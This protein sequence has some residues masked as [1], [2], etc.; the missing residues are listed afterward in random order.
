MLELGIYASHIIWRIR[1]RK[2]R[3]EAKARGKSIDE[4][5]DAQKNGTEGPRD[6]ESGVV[7]AEGPDEAPSASP[8]NKPS[9]EGEKC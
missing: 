1:Y 4:L 8:S 5:L 2:L 7:V 9:D 3:K 6:I